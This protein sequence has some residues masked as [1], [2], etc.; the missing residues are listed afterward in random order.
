M[1]RPMP[2]KEWSAAPCRRC[3]KTPHSDY[4]GYCRECAEDLAL[5]G[6]IA[7]PLGQSAG[8][9]PVESDLEH[10]TDD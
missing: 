2:K 3:G 9:A 10:T 1:M 5:R 7:S 6:L 4:E 8:E